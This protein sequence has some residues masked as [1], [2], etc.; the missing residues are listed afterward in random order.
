M[1]SSTKI[2]KRAVDAANPTAA[3]YT[4][5][6]SELKGFGIRVAQSGTK[7]YFVRHR[8]RGARRHLVV[9]CRHGVITPDEARNR[10]RMILG[11]V[12]AGDGD[13]RCFW[14]IDY[15]DEDMELMSSNPADPAVTARVLTVMLAEEY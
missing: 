9:L 3:R 14:K 7:T 6:D 15:Y 11:A 4:I 12:A 2:T 5:W 13:I 10:A 8:V 1:T